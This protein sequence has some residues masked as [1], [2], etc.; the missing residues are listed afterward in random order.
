MPE[1]PT[2]EDPRIRLDVAPNTQVRARLMP[3]FLTAEEAA[4]WLRTTKGAVM[5]GLQRGEI[6]GR[7]VGGEW[8]IS[9]AAA[10]ALFRGAMP[11]GGTS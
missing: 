3:D 7:K 4:D 2:A 9:T 6:P 5:A 10:L 11:E 1:R 8:R